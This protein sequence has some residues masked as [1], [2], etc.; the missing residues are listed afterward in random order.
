MRAQSNINDLLARL[1]RLQIDDCDGKIEKG[2]PEHFEILAL[3]ELELLFIKQQM[4]KLYETNLN[5]SGRP[6]CHVRTAA[7]L[8]PLKY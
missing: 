5:L 8:C 6:V 1:H 2:S 4:Q 7:G 3:E